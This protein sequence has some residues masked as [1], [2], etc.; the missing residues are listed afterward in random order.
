MLACALDSVRQGRAL[1]CYLPARTLNRQ[2][3]V[4]RVRAEPATLPRAQSSSTHH[5]RGSHKEIRG[6]LAFP[7][8]RKTSP[9]PIRPDF[10]LHIV[11]GGPNTPPKNHKAG[12]VGP[13]L[14]LWNWFGQ[15]CDQP[16]ECLR[17]G[18]TGP[19][20]SKPLHHQCQILQFIL[21]DRQSAPSH[22][23]TASCVERRLGRNPIAAAHQKNL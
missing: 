6:C 5:D 17:R 3:G 9:A 12:L 23:H 7:A 10:D 16:P 15:S 20:R 8:T 21:Q 22:L 18:V 14:S 13:A 1:L 19:R 11:L 2:F 4:G